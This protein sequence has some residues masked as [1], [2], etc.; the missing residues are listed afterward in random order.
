M[1]F[2]DSNPYFF[3]I[4]NFPYGEINQRSF[5]STPGPDRRQAIIWTNAGILVIG[6]LG[7]NISDVLT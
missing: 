3:K 6:P 2:K 4:D 1:W 5:S 7:T